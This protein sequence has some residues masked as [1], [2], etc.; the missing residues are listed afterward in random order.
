MCELAFTVT[1]SS[2]HKGW[3]TC[4]T[5]DELVENDLNRIEPIQRLRLATIRNTMPISLAEIP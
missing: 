1:T 4:G 5:C 2:G 3:H